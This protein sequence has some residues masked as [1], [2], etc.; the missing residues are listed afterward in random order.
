MMLFTQMDLQSMKSGE[1]LIPMYQPPTYTKTHLI[2]QILVQADLEVVVETLGSNYMSCKKN[3]FYARKQSGSHLAKS[4][5][6][7]MGALGLESLE[8]CLRVLFT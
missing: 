6:S 5:C 4:S 3:A 7:S 1:P 2:D 8:S